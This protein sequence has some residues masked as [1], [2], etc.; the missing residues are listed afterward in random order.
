VFINSIYSQSLLTQLEKE[1]TDE[2]IYEIATFKTTRIGLG[3]SIETRKKGAL[4]ISLFNRFWNHEEET[5]QRFLAD[6]V[7]IR[8]GL[9]YA[10]TDNLTFGI[11]YSNF[12]K[13]TDSFLKYKILKQQKGSKKAPL[14]I[15]LFQGF[16]HKKNSTTYSTNYQSN[17]IDSD[18]YSFV[19][20]V[21]IAKKIN[22]VFSVQIAPTYIH[23][24]K[25]VFIDQPNNQ[26]AIGAGGRYKV[27]GHLSIVSEYYHALNTEKSTQTFNPFMVGV[28]WELSHLLLQFQVTNARTF[29]E[30]AFIT[31]TENNFNF[32]DGNFHFGVNATFVLHLR[33]NKL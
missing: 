17:T 10:I 23:R 25:S 33:K 22:Q 24:N 13:I 15:A 2:P 14:S 19:S 27:N 1:H 26:F 3:H 31:Q 5:T 11:G 28:N 30:D 20:Q 4:E 16:S 6:E 12:D 18:I 9:D 29:S 32:H 8:F 21:L 7:N